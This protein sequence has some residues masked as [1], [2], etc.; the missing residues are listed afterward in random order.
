MYAF[1]FDKVAIE[2]YGMTADD[3]YAIVR[4]GK[5]TIDKVAEVTKNVYKDLNGNNERDKDDY[6]GFASSTR[7]PLNTFMWSCDNPI[8]K[9]DSDG[10]PQLVYYQDKTPSVVEKVMGLLFDSTGSYTDKKDYD[11]N[12]DMFMTGNAVDGSRH[13]LR[14]DDVFP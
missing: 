11:L 3:L 4:D 7:S 1:F 6:Y 9:S 2:D 5:W 14:S 10:V 13:I 12:R 8:M